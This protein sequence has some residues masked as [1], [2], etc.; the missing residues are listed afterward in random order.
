MLALAPTLGRRAVLALALAS[1]LALSG[2]PAH[3][4]DVTCD[5]VSDFPC[6]YQL[7]DLRLQKVPSVFKFQARVSQAKLPIGEGV[8]N[9]VYVKLLRGTQVVC[10]EQF[11]GVQVV[12][13][14]LNL[15]IGRNMSCELDEV[16]AEN[17]DLAFQICPGGVEN[18][19]QPVSLGSAPYAIKASFASIAQQAH[20]ANFAGQCSYAHRV[21]ADRDLLI[22]SRLGTGY[23]DFYT[24]SADKALEVYGDPADYADYEN[25]GFLQ[26]TPVKDRGALDLHIVGKRQDGDRMTELRSLHLVSEDTTATGDLTITPSEDGKGLT[27]TLRGM[28]V[29]GDS[30]V[31]GTLVVTQATTVESGGVHVVGDSDVDGQMD[32]SGR[33]VVRSGGAHVT[34]DSEVDGQLSVSGR[35]A[36]QSGGVHVVGDSDVTGAM[37]VSEALTVASGGAHVTGASDVD[38]ALTV[39]VGGVHVTGDSNVAG[40]LDVSDAVSVASGG[41]HVVGDSSVDGLLEAD[42]VR[43]AGSL[44]VLDSVGDAHRVFSIVGAELGINPDE[45]VQATRVKGVVRFDGPVI[46]DGGTTDPSA[47]ETFILSDGE[48]RDLTFGGDLEVIGA[49]AL[50]G[51]VSGALAVAGDISATGALT[52]GGAA[53]FNGPVSVPGG[54]TGEL[55]IGGPVTVGG[56]ATFNGAVSVPGGVSGTVAVDG[57]VTTT[58]GA[59]V[60]GSLSVTG[61]STFG[62][63]ASFP[64]GV[65][66]STSFGGPASLA[67]TLDVVGQTHLGQLTVGG[68]MS[69]SG[70][71]TFEGTTTFVGDV[72]GN[73]NF[74]NN[75]A[76]S[77]TTT[78]GGNTNVGGNLTIDGTTRFNGPVNFGGSFSGLTQFQSAAVSSSFTVGGQSIFNG[79]VAFP[80]GITGSVSLDT[81]TVGTALV[82]NNNAT[83]K[84]PVDFQGAVTGI[85][86]SDVSG[87]NLG[88]FVKASGETRAITLPGLLVTGDA[89]FQGDVTFPNGVS[90]LDVGQLRAGKLEA[91]CRICLNYADGEGTDAADRKHACVAM[92]DGAYSGLMHLSGDVDDNDVIGIKFLCDGGPSENGSG[93]K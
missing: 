8:F 85:G 11:T 66:G 60:G 74:R 7:R 54:M 62:G 48:T 53:T 24:P 75:V 67:S 92:V 31:D 59:S 36:I 93:W 46:F 82:A 12:D 41:V 5:G 64:G 58:G 89:T 10:M 90:S 63:A 17:T 55:A 72:V 30:D 4:E 6:S 39:S 13:S 80:G 2:S 76:V 73:A 56:A 44:Q 37:S 83:F 86:V 20:H 79:A 47:A 50:R 40:A 87:L 26:W 32:I 78:L 16:I 29:T 1:L 81:L 25:G 34:G 68:A 43:V 70:A 71:T 65:S 42:D 38:G 52:V 57:A 14:V 15:E 49:T 35:T 33:T 88:D 69:V 21:T 9:T 22:R 19:L 61:S 28:H 45:S 27:V 91:G 3:A 23:F 77:G 84:G 18:C 51:G